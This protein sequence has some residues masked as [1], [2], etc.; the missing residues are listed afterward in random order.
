MSGSV[1]GAALPWAAPDAGGAEAPQDEQELALALDAVGL[2]VGS[3]IEVGVRGGLRRSAAPSSA[4]RAASRRHR[5]ACALACGE[6][7]A[8]KA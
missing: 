8:T 5:C 6:G 7:C 2:A 1:P 3:R 4:V